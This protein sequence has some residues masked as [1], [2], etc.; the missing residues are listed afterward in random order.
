MNNDKI[1]LRPG[2]NIQLDYDTDNVAFKGF[3]NPVDALY[4]ER[5]R[6]MIKVGVFQG[7]LYDMKQT[8]VG[9]WKIIPSDNPADPKTVQCNLASSL[10]STEEALNY[11]R[12]IKKHY[13]SPA[14]EKIEQ[15]LSLAFGMID[16]E[17]QIMS[18]TLE[19]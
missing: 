1:T 18:D 13:Q 7:P 2:L 4:I 19:A 15:I 6:S 11:I 12:G 8:Q 17:Q 9:T 5:I 3:K 16:T 10:N 14:L